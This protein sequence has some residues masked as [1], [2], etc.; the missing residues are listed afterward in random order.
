MSGFLA[1]LVLTLGCLVARG[2]DRLLHEA[3][4]T[5]RHPRVARRLWTACAASQVGYV[6]ALALLLAHDVWEHSLLWLTGAAK[7]D[8]HAA[9][10]GGR[11]VSTTWNWT[12]VLALVALAAPAWSW[13][14]RLR[15]AEHRRQ[16]HRLLPGRRRRWDD[17]V[18]LLT[19]AAGPALYCLPGRRLFG[20]HPPLI[21]ASEDAW[22][23]LTDEERRAAVAHELAHLRRR[24]HR[25]V[26][27]AE[28]FAA[29]AGRLGALPHYAT[30]MRR[31]VELEADD[32]AGRAHGRHAVASAL[33]RLS[34]GPGGPSRSP[35]AALSL[36]GRDVGR[37]VRRLLD[38]AAPAGL[39][40]RATA[41]AAAT[42]LVAAPPALLASPL[43]LVL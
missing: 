14:R 35:E 41:R 26:A 5:W 16:A 1:L 37:R 20:S 15:A 28:T 11:D 24:H 21:I 38:P 9:Y 43:L 40:L 27:M 39:S 34:T 36:G 17:A 32:D 3:A 10:A 23:R 31:L 12:V 30:E 22:T 8:L 2:A 42:C 25:S 29:T 7:S 18:L 6:L 13:V 33:L 19:P 4:W